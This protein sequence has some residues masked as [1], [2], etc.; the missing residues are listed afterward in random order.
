MKY[1]TLTCGVDLKDWIEKR[2]AFLRK[3]GNDSSRLDRYRKPRR[4]PCAV[5]WNHPMMN[6]YGSRD[7]D[8]MF[9]Y[10]VGKRFS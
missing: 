4:F 2:K 1:E 9:L 5:V 10:D 8:Y 3:N 7:I 6:S